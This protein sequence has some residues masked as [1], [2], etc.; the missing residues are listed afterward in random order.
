MFV[1]SSLLF[2]PRS[3]PF[4]LL[5]TLLLSCSLASSQNRSH[6][7]PSRNHTHTY[8]C[9]SA[10]ISHSSF[11]FG[12]RR[13]QKVLRRWS[14]LGAAEWE[15]LDLQPH[16]PL[17]IE[18]SRLVSF[19]ISGA[20]RVGGVALHAFDS[21]TRRDDL[22]LPLY[23]FPISLSRCTTSSTS[24][25]F[26]YF[27]SPACLSLFSL[28]ISHRRFVSFPLL[29]FD[30]RSQRERVVFLPPLYRSRSS[31][32]IASEYSH[33]WLI[34]NFRL[35]HAFRCQDAAFELELPNSI[36]PPLLPSSRLPSLELF[37]LLKNEHS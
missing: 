7:R 12:R 30:G 36:P 14:R 37:L 20:K 18:E 22:L 5:L 15:E 26:L 25:S 10:T 21:E 1:S 35:S 31:S 13:C 29:L 32:L 4:L 6:L 19:C 27:S 11:S 9:P 28:W 34:R 3:L 16:N 8:S 33:S 24:H 17:L 23:F 2:L